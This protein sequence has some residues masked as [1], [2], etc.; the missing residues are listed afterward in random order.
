MVR[1]RITPSPIVATPPAPASIQE[2]AGPWNAL[3]RLRDLTR[4]RAEMEARAAAWAAAN[5][6]PDQCARLENLSGEMER[7]AA[8]GDQH[9]FRL[10]H[11][12]FHMS[13]YRAAG[14]DA[15]LGIIGQLW[16]AAEFHS[17]LLHGPDCPGDGCAGHR[18]ILKA[19]RNRDVE[20]CAQLIREEIESHLYAR[21]D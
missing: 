11:R 6:T 9:A 7:S 17:E 21:G 20:T 19:L 5:I 18:P 4:V 2:V 15:L 14:S 3:P 10:R 12:D 13:L 1:S 16:A 8:T